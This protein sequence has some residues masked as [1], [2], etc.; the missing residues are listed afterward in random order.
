[1]GTSP[2][3][4]DFLLDQLDHSLP[5]TTRKMFGEYCVYWDG[6]PVAFVCDDQLFVKPTNAGRAMQDPVVE[7]V[8]YPGAKMY[9]LVE[10][11]L[12]ERRE[13]LGELLRV[14]AEEMPAPREKTR[15]RR[16]TR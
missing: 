9:L 2:Q 4:M 7:G 12:W 10:A 6:K 3:T 14:T 11:D 16:L 5:I 1:M 15:V 8:P 13:W